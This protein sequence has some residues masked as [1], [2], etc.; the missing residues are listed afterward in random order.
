MKRDKIKRGAA[1][2]LFVFPYFALFLLFVAIPVVIA[3]G[4]SFT[5]FNAIQKPSFVGLKN[6]VE[7]FLQDEVFIEHVIPNTII[8]AVIVGPGF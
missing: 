5:D 7:L 8:F 2:Y 3:I 6:Y 4:L 1:P